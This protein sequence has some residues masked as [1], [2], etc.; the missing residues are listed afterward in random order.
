MLRGNGGQD[1][2]FFD[3]DRCRFYQLLQ[4]MTASTSPDLNGLLAAYDLFQTKRSTR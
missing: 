4:E 3:A 2:F 1:I